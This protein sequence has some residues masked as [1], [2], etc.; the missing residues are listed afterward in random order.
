MKVLPT[1]TGTVAALHGPRQAQVLRLLA[2]GRTNKEIA[3]ALGM[4]LSTVK[5]HVGKILWELG[6]SNRTEIARWA[7]LNPD[8][9]AG[10]AV[11]TSIHAPG[12]PCTGAYCTMMRSLDQAEKPAA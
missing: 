5:H 1:R 12:C 9:F 7:L 11:E 10:L 2:I 3:H 8:I 4:S 6:L